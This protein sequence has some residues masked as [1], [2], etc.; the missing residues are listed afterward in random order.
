MKKTIIFC[1]L[2]LAAVTMKAQL[3]VAILEPVDKAQNVSYAVKFLL[4]SSLT[5]AI[6]NTPGYEGYDR[7]DMTSISGE[8][9]FQRTGNVSDEQI[10]QLGVATGAAYV[11]VT[12]AAK[13]DENSII[14]SAKILDVETFGIKKSAVQVSGVKADELQ[15][16]CN[17]MAAKLLGT[18]QTAQNNVSNQP[19]ATTPATTSEATM[20]KQ[21]QASTTIP[22]PSEAKLLTTLPDGNTIYVAL[23][24]EPKNLNHAQAEQACSCKGDGWRLPTDLELN[25]MYINKKE[26]GGFSIWVCYW[27]LEGNKIMDMGVGMI[28]PMLNPNAKAKVR[29][30]KEVK[31]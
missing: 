20:Q 23:K 31:P 15:E 19:K 17:I 5:T 24:D 2:C 14:I 26:I 4:R 13:Y 21:T 16:S 6:T 8:Q 7:V 18:E 9:E 10:K 22:N 3:R 30:V 25:A 12:E 11:L 28:R 1:F 29:C 27:N